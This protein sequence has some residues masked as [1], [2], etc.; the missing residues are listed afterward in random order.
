MIL[1][2]IAQFDTLPKE[3]SARINGDSVLVGWL[4]DAQW[5]SVKDFSDVIPAGVDK[6]KVRHDDG[7]TSRNGRSTIV[8]RKGDASLRGDWLHPHLYVTDLKR[9]RNTLTSFSIYYEI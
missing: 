8:K 2:Y 4:V 5:N 9:H 6:A 1:S 3:D 7:D